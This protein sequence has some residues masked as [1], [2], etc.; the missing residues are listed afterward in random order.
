[1]NI[2][3]NITLHVNA[4]APFDYWL[5]FNLPDDSDCKVIG[6][7]ENEEPEESG[8]NTL[9]VKITLAHTSEAGTP[10]LTSPLP[11]LNSEIEEVKFIFD[12]TVAPTSGGNVIKSTSA[13]KTSKPGEEH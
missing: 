3:E 10:L 9:E 1:M 2:D 5:S 7:N 11:N 4:N 12:G 6:A 8:E 13:E